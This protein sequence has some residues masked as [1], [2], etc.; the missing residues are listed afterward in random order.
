MKQRGQA[1]AIAESDLNQDVVSSGFACIIAINDS[2][3]VCIN[4]KLST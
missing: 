2:L 3:F 1:A 4:L